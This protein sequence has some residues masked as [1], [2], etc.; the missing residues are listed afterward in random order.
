MREYSVDPQ[1]MALH[2]W[3]S[4]EQGAESG[5]HAIDFLESLVPPLEVAII[6]ARIFER[7]T[8]EE[9]AERFQV[10]RSSAQRLEAKG[11]ERIRNALTNNH[12]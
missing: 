12:I 8:W 6:E 9:I 1:R 7:L 5:T 3:L 2:L 4:G 11:L 10:S